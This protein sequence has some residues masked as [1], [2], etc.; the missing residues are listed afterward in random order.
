M[1]GGGEREGETQNAA[2]TRP[3]PPP[4]KKKPTHPPTPKKQ[5]DDPTKYGVVVI[6]EATGMVQRFVEKPQ[7]FVG[8]KINAGIYVLSPKVCFLGGQ[9][10]CCARRGS[11]VAR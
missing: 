9:E 10:A 4:Q 11:V 6:D 7:T 3:P 5:V 8:D 2:H 1:W